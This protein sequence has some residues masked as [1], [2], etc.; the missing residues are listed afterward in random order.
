MSS[1]GAGAAGRSSRCALPFYDPPVHDRLL[2]L[3]LYFQEDER[4]YQKDA[5]IEDAEMYN[6]PE[7]GANEAGDEVYEQDEEEDEG[8]DD[9]TDPGALL[10]LRNVARKRGQLTSGVAE[11][12][13]EFAPKAY[14]A[15]NTQLAV[16]YKDGM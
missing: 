10:S 3:L 14:K 8:S 1:S 4:E 7:E 6:I 12:E 13:R 2:I 11:D 16:G 9:E 5:Y 15:K